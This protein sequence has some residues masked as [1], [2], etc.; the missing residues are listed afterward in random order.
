[1][2]LTTYA[3]LKTSVADFLNRTDLTSAIPTFISLAEA[4]FNRKI[5]HWRMEKR[6]TAE[7]SAQYTAPPADF[8]EPI[9]LSM[10]S[11][12]T[13]RLE[14]ISQSQMMEQ[15][16]LGQNTSGTPRFYAITDGSIEVYPNPNSDDLTVEMVYYGKPTAL[17]DSNATNW[18]LTY[19]PRCVSIWRIGSQRALPCRR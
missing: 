4:D 3:E 17:S 2:A 5:R 19:Y 18:L 15:R 10:L 1:M 12:N 13:S 7:M 11:G 16:Q 14:P 6:S 8:L 9:R